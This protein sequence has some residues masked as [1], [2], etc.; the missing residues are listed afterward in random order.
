MLLA[1]T[2]DRWA[3]P[4]RPMT[5]YVIAIV[6]IGRQITAQRLEQLRRLLR[7]KLGHIIAEGALQFPIGLRVTDRGVN[8]PDIEVRAERRKQL[9][10]E[11]GAVVK[12]HRVGDD[13][14]LPHR[15]DQ[16]GDRRP[17]VWRQEEVTEDVATGVII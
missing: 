3:P 9:A 7:V 1:E 14:P 11:R 16:R 2:R 5:S 4:Q 15:R 13:L 6:H 8:Q 10:L 12:H 17:L